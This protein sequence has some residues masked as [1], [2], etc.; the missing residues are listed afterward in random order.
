MAVASPL[1]TEL[2]LPKLRL[3]VD[4]QS[5]QLSPI[6]I[7]S[8]KILALS[9]CKPHPSNQFNPCHHLISLL[10]TP[11]LEYLELSGAN[12]PDLARYF[13]NPSAF[14]KL[15]TLRLV[16]VSILG[17][18]MA[19]NPEPD[20]GDYL[21]GL[22][23]VEELEL[24]CSHAE[25]LL[26]TEKQAKEIPVK[27]RPRT[28]SISRETALRRFGY[29][30]P[31]PASH[32]PPSW[33]KEPSNPVP[34][35]PNLRSISLD[36]LIAEEVLWLY[37]LVSERPQIKVVKLSRMTERHLATSLGTV[38]GVLETLPHS[39]AKRMG[40]PDPIPVDAGKLLRER[41]VVKEIENNG[42]IP[43]QG[44]EI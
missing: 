14:T 3:M 36:T 38:D 37:R 29:P 40:A 15:R 1:L 33:A 22:T 10:S 23:T 12:V 25:Y 8:L 27:G 11:N 13:Q 21:R 39:I 35:Y 4:L 34:I 18:W 17:S 43:G 2:V 41:V 24:I 20:N 6:E 44:T 31:Q 28:N 16:N 32:H 7:P 5:E 19:R 42:Y 30:L 9:F 26:S